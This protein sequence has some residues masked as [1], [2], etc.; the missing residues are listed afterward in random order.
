MTRRFRSAATART[1]AADFTPGIARSSFDRAIEHRP[2]LLRRVVLR[3]RQTELRRE[4]MIAVEAGVDA[5]QRD[6]ATA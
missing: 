3:R 1:S 2:D 5:L 4:Q 6:A